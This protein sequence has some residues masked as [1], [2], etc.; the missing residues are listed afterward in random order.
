M[1]TRR[2]Y[3]MRARAEAAGATRLRILEATEK[4]LWERLD[5]E[6]HLDAIAERAGV[7]V[8]TVLRVFGS[9][10][11][12]IEVATNSIRAQVQVQRRQAPP[13]DIA[14]SI[15]ALFDHYEEV[16]DV[17]IRA[18]AEESLRR[19]LGDNLAVGRQVHRAWVMEQFAP[20]LAEVAGA[21]RVSLVDG[22]VVACDVYA[23]KLLRRDQ[24][25]ERP[26]AEAV[27]RL[28]VGGLLGGAQGV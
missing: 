7:S 27:M 9:R 24:E 6:V 25:R 4:L 1:K 28:I 13:G 20:Q 2:P 19:T 26:A 18:L 22:L 16:G 15:R 8:Q 10:A 12:L 17:V 14:G 5:A 11:D 23:W 3:R 21:A